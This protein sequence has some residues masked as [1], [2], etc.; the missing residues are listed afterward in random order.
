MHS[1]GSF[2][3]THFLPIIGLPSGNHFT[4]DFNKH[5]HAYIWD[6]PTSASTL[7][8]IKAGQLYGE[9]S[10]DGTLIAAGGWTSG[11]IH[12]FDAYTQQQLM[13]LP[14]LGWGHWSPD[15][16]RFVTSTGPE[17]FSVYDV[18]TGDELF[19]LSVCWSCPQVG[20]RTPYHRCR[21]AAKDEFNVYI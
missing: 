11:N 6:L 3:T 15:S 19:H 14:A 9:W 12:I 4:N 16:T 7:L 2:P 13:A 1:G 5:G 8:G 18:K 20:R 21:I 17:S 10:P